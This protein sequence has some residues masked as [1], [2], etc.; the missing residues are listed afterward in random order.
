MAVPLPPL[1]DR[2]DDIPL[3]LNHYIDGFNTEFRKKV[4]G[5]TPGAMAALK[6][7]RVAGQRARAAQRRRAGDAAQRRAPS[8]ARNTFRCWGRA[9]A[10]LSAEVE[11]PAGGHQPRGA[12]AI[13]GGAGARAERAGTRPRRPRCSASTAI[14]SAIASR[15]SSSKSLTSCPSR[16]PSDGQLDRHDRPTAVGTFHGDAPV[17]QLDQSLGRGHAEAGAARLGGL[18]RPEE[19][20]R[21][22][23]REYRDPDRRSRRRASRRPAP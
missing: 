20:L 7:Y 13:A 9:M 22:S 5:V 6:T 23:R 14:R 17:V 19:R 3:L 11:L 8:S 21:G 2:R 12:G 18:E 10:R 1:R 16:Q 15:S 4:R